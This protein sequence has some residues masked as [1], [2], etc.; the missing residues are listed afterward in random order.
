MFAIDIKDRLIRI[1]GPAT[2]S[3]AAEI[4]S[5]LLRSAAG[6]ASPWVVDLSAATRIDS[7]VVQ[8]L[9]ARK[10][11]KPRV[12]IVGV[13]PDQ[14]QRWNRLGISSHLLAP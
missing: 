10:R 4:K 14:L 12:S 9:I 7:C 2:I 13:A 8:L 1:A 11:V 6:D 5:A 3:H